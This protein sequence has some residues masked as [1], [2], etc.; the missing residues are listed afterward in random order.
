MPKLPLAKAEPE[1][2]CYFSVF[3]GPDKSVRTA[4]S[5]VGG[6]LED[7]IAYYVEKDLA[8]Q[9]QYYYYDNP[10][11]VAGALRVYKTWPFT[12][13]AALEPRRSLDEVK[14]DATLRRYA[15]IFAAYER[16]IFLRFASEMNGPW[17]PYYGNPSLYRQKFRLVSETMKRLAPNVIMLWCVSHKPGGNWDAYYPGDD[18][19][20]WAGVN[21]YSVIHHNGDVKQRADHEHPASLLDA[22]YRK[23]A[24]RKPIAICEYGA[25]H[26]EKLQPGVDR[27]D[28][29][30]EKYTQ[31]LT[32][33]PKKYPR[34]KMVGLFN[35]NTMQKGFQTASVK[36]NNF[37]F[38]D[39]PVVYTALRRALKTDYYLSDVI[40]DKVPPKALWTRSRE[41]G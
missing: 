28:W 12:M 32:I 5:R 13:Q 17:T 24:A 6:R 40:G 20:D 33:L 41:S 16:P 7:G 35:V 14:D 37:C 18:Y 27:S 29:A 38:T 11:E 15:E 21:F 10:D 39:S 3:V 26:E 2:G 36:A 4:M 23:Y 30:A 9:W 8:V 1:K 19:V 25:T 34:V 31:L 22:F